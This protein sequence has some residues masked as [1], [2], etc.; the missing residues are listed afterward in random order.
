MELHVLEINFS[1]G[2]RE[3]T[4][5][6]VVLREGSETILVD[7]GYA[8]FLPLL[9]AAMEK[10]GLSLQDLTGVII[11]HHDID[12]MGALAE[13]KE[14][15][16]GLKVYASS[17]EKPYIEGMK[18]SL[19]LQ[20][21]EDL[22]PCLPEEQKEGAAQFQQLLKSVRPVAVDEEVHPEKDLPVLPGV[23]AIATPGHL[24]GHLSLYLREQ[25]VLVAA[26]A[27]VYDGGAFDIANPQ[28]ALDLPAAIASV[29]KLQQLP[30][31]TV[32]CFHGGV[33]REGVREGLLR[34]VARYKKN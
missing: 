6:P 5:F 15:Y 27:L 12:H 26:D 31:E 21:A 22:Y 17:L 8:G 16:P 25:K 3:D 33:V 28:Y 11:S 18:K 4:L 2:G 32:V 30:I 20:Q 14:Q 29:E 10:Q 24:P 9:E 23:R 19:R 13:L 7:C 34:L 1:F